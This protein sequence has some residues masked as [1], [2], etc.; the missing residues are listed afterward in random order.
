[1]PT[2]EAIEMKIK[3]LQ[4]QAEAIAAKQALATLDRIRDL[5]EKHGVTLADIEAH[6]G[7]KKR[8]SMHGTA[9]ATRSSSAAKYQEP[10]TGATWSGRGRAPAWIASVKDRS[11]FLVDVNASTSSPVAGGKAKRLGA[12]IRGPQPPKYRDPKT[13]ASWSGR[14][15]A[16]AWIKNVKNRSKFLIAAD[17]KAEAT[18]A[19]TSKKARK[20][21]PATTTGGS[22]KKGQP[23]GKQPAKYLNPETGATWSGRGPAPA[24]LAAA[25]DRSKFLVDAASA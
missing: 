11:R 14:G 16:P 3:R 8:G 7:Q 17:T 25:K 4:E 2:L 19:T 15:P 20:K 24:W 9:T 1:V 12:Y 21:V 18:V 13:G 10:K 6:I 22:A 5:M 23:R